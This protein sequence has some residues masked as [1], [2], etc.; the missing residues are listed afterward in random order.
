MIET[1]CLSTADDSANSIRDISVAAA[2]IG[3]CATRS[4]LKPAHLAF[5]TGQPKPVRD[6]G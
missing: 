6:M 5:D 4:Q 3:I 1:P 2:K